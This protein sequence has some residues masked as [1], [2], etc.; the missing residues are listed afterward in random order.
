MKKIKAAGL[1]LK[2]GYYK[3]GNWYDIPQEYVTETGFFYKTE[4]ASYSL[5]LTETEYG[6]DYRLEE[7]ATFET[8]LRFW[9]EGEEKEGFHVIPCNLYGDNNIDRVKPGEF[10]S[11]TSRYP[12]TRFCSP[13]W[14]FRADR[15]AMPLTAMTLGELAVGIAIDPYCNVPGGHIHNGIEAGLPSLVG[16]S[17]GYENF[18]VTFVDKTNAGEPT[19]ESAAE[20][21]AGG[22]IYLYSNGGKEGIHLMIREEYGKKHERAVFKKNFREAA[23]AMV[24]A[25]TGLNWN[26]EWQAYTD[27]SCKPSENTLLKAWRPVYE[28]GWTGIGELACPLVAA[29]ELLQLPESAFG[30]AKTGEALIEQVV[31]AYN[32][33]SGLLNDLVAP[34]DSSGSLVNGWWIWYHIASDC[35]CAYNNGKAVHEIL[36]TICFLKDRGKP[37]PVH[38]LDTCLKVL[39]TISTLQAEDGHYG[40]TY[41]TE[42]KKVLDWDG[43]A[44]CW[45]L[46]C[47]AYAYSLTGQEAYLESARKAEGFYR[48]YVRDL[49][50]Y[51][52]PMDTWKAVDEEGN[53]AFIRGTRLLHEITGE[54]EYLKDLESGAQYEYLWRYGYRTRP[55][56]APVKT[57]WNSCGGSV[58]SISNPH[59]HP[60]GVIVDDDLRYLADKT[61]DPYHQSR[62]DDSTAWM[63]QNLECYPEK[64]GYGRYGVVSER[65]CPSDGLVTE[66]D[67]D[68]TP[69]ASWFTYNMWSAANILEALT[70][71]IGRDM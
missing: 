59:I 4:E 53:L 6:Y 28:I 17:L 55:E 2:G 22:S 36:K 3:E 68:G 27:M 16:V 35:H 20:A 71:I 19:A 69:Y 14:A 44:G 29:R 48:K 47:M 24:D 13:F 33:V 61:G 15:A 66:R 62:A 52:T 32:P 58:T 45:F 41:S 18:P 51:G 42:E 21:E 65:W 34:V 49:N 31:G 46:P 57:G 37:Y 7:K 9:L 30:K 60:M 70:D 40:Y 67:S 1:S 25:F 50:C 11:L 43:F 56:Y 38:W 64:T 5:R 12:G 10:P 8:R 54:K 39:N 63:M 23:A 26:E